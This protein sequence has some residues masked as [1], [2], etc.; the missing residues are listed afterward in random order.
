MRKW[1]VAYL[2][3]GILIFIGFSI[4]M[5]SIIPSILP[6]G[7][8]K[9]LTATIEPQ[10]YIYTSTLDEISLGSISGSFMATPGTVDF[11]IFT[12]EQYDVYSRVGTSSSVLH[13]S[14]ESEE[15]YA[16]LSGGG[17]FYIVAEHGSGS[18]WDKHQTFTMEYRISG[19]PSF[20]P[21][22]GFVIV[23]FG[24]A[25][26]VYGVIEKRREPHCEYVEPILDVTI[27]EE[28]EP[29]VLLNADSGSVDPTRVRVT[30]TLAKK[31]SAVQ[32]AVTP[33]PS[34]NE[35]LRNVKKEN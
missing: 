13:A 19:F 3:G 26:V 28:R 14:G 1:R 32:N 16:D 31:P 35:E 22:V 9:T 11:Y 17:H 18:Y 10:H 7:E 27:F 2:V 6:S 4:A 15:F 30:R 29:A 21:T 23:L 34:E 33:Q 24:A 8:M 20:F 5:P 12:E 25:V